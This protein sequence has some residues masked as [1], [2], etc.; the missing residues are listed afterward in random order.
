MSGFAELIGE[1]F[2]FADTAAGIKVPCIRGQRS[3]TLPI[4]VSEPSSPNLAD[5]LA[6][7][8]K[9]WRDR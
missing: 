8:G 9:V 2:N 3:E 7:P 1:L 6:D 4:G 5:L